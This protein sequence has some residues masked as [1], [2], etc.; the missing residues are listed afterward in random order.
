MS[1]NSLLKKLLGIALVVV[2][3]ARFEGGSL[4]VSVRPRKSRL[5]RC[6]E[7][8]RRCPVH[9][10]PPAPRRWRSL[11]LGSTM[12]FLEYA[13]PRV[14]CPEHGVHAAGVPWAHH[15][16]RFTRDF[17]E[18][19]AW[20]C[21]HCNRST[22]SRLMRIDWK[23]VGGICKRVY[24]RL[25]AEAG[26]RFDGLVRIGVDETSYKKGHKYMTVVVDHDT[27]RVV[28]CARGHGKAVLESFFDL[29]TDGQRASVEVVTADGARWIAD[30]VA[31]RCPNAERAMDPFHVVQWMTD[32]LDE[33]RKEAWREAR[34]V[35]KAAEKAAPGRKRGRPRK[36]E[37]RPGSAAKAVKGSRYAL[38]K[39]PEDLTAGQQA[40][41]EKV[42]RENKALYRAYL[43]KEDLRDV[44]KSPDPETAGARL[45]KWLARACRSRN[46]KVKELSKKVRRHR[47]AI[48][49]SVELGISNARVEA[50]NNKI[51]LTVRMG[52]G[53]RNIDN[54]IALVMLRCSNLPIALPGRKAA[55]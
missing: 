11:D 35:E 12:V 55:A 16:S 34:K 7:C 41:L 32:V 27:G 25:D 49:R 39:N 40:S 21:V 42:A 3:S 19:V 43:L 23:S 37:G 52:Y 1:V 10:C 15:R 17:E 51:K 45:D 20:L 26:S 28:W 4:I 9:D 54:L 14:D 46:E 36:G 33:V 29:L 2:K 22:V 6:H 18:Q 47:G 48:L 5:C 44:F 13:L 50:I 53:F 8:G 38:L 31:E 24:D 30:V